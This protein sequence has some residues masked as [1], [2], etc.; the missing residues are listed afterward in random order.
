MQCGLVVQ[1]LYLT[2]WQGVGSRDDSETLR[3]KTSIIT[4]LD[5][6]LIQNTKIV[7]DALFIMSNIRKKI[8][9]VGNKRRIC[10]AYAIWEALHINK[11]P[12]SLDEIATVCAVKESQILNFEKDL[13][14]QHTYCSPTLY[15]ER[16]C[17]SLQLPYCF[18]AAIRCIIRNTPRLAQHKPS[19]IVVTIIIRLIEL[20]RKSE[21]DLNSLRADSFLC[22]FLSGLKHNVHRFS[23]REWNIH[24]VCSKLGTIT[25]VIYRMLRLLSLDAVREILIRENMT[26]Y[27]NYD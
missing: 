14:L 24:Y 9:L 21:N 10:H 15:V 2:E 26:K 19:N 25:G 4:H 27:E 7:D 18:Q 23:Q 3:D 20:A 17:D 11:C 16:I 1:Q 8:R 6:L 13:N 5:F 12:R 22:Y